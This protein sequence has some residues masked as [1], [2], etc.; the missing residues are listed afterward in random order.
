MP[1]KRL[2]PYIPA[3]RVGRLAARW[4]SVRAQRSWVTSSETLGELPEEVV[5]EATV[6]EAVFRGMVDL[7]FPRK[8]GSCGDAVFNLASWPFQAYTRLENDSAELIVRGSLMRC[9]LAPRTAST[10]CGWAFEFEWS[11]RASVVGGVL[12]FEQMSPSVVLGASG[13]R[14]RALA[15]PRRQFRVRPETHRVASTQV[16][17]SRSGAKWQGAE[18]WRTWCVLDPDRRVQVIDG[19]DQAGLSV[20]AETRIL[21]VL[22]ISK[23]KELLECVR[24]TCSA[25]QGSF[26]IEVSQDLLILLRYGPNARGVWDQEG[27]GVVLLDK[28]ELQ[29]GDAYLLCYEIA[30]QVLSLGW[31]LACRAHGPKCLELEEALRTAAAIRVADVVT[32][33][34]RSRRMLSRLRAKAILAAPS[35]V[36]Q[37]LVGEKQH[38][39]VFEYALRLLRISEEHGNHVFQRLTELGWGHSTKTD[40]IWRAASLT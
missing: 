35:Q 31:G 28:E 23:A 27:P 24:R 2:I 13:Q 38:R 39:A 6:A 29:Q 12:L 14:A 37:A 40:V 9:S 3:G 8:N 18:D 22:G 4:E 30:R 21:E 15:L 19:T 5:V 33:T 34:S 1:H 32:G 10:Q 20:M 16:A 36:W 7:R 17:L 25:L 26:G 11:P